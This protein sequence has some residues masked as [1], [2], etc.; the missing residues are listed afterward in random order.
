MGFKN[1]KKIVEKS[2]EEDGYISCF[3]VDLGI[4]IERQGK[5]ILR[6]RDIQKY[7]LTIELFLELG[8]IEHTG[9]WDPFHHIILRDGTELR[10]PNGYCEID[11]VGGG[12]EDILFHVGND[13]ELTDEELTENEKKYIFEKDETRYYRIKQSLIQSISL[14]R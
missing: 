1:L 10:T 12:I 5:S 9:D 6:F 3:L 14:E 4:R 2:K 7:Q 13:E 8:E 11:I